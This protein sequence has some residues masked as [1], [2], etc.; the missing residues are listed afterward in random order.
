MLSPGGGSLPD[1]GTYICIPGDSDEVSYPG[2]R[3]F[4][5]KADIWGRRL[6]VYQYTKL[7]IEGDKVG[8]FPRLG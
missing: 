7:I 8:N 3:L 4:M 5:L 6:D 1:V 2:R